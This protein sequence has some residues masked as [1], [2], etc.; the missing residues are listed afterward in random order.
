MYGDKKL[1]PRTLVCVWNY[2][3]LVTLLELQWVL[4]T[5]FSPVVPDSD[6][7]SPSI[8]SPRPYFLVIIGDKERSRGN[9]EIGVSVT[10]L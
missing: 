1:N 9:I 7:M 8:R 10:A 2:V 4:H 5:L 6:T 3:H